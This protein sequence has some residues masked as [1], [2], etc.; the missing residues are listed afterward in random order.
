MA[1]P[2]FRNAALER[3]DITEGLPG[4]RL[5]LTLRLLHPDCTTPLADAWVDIWHCDAGGRYSGWSAIDPNVEAPS[6]EIGSIPRTDDDTYLRGHRLSDENGQVSF[7]TVFPGFYAGRAT[8][9]HVAVRQADALHVAYVGQL[10]FPPLISRLVSDS[11][12]YGS[13]PIT[14]LENH[15]DELYVETQTHQAKNLDVA[16]SSLTDPGDRLLGF[17]EFSLDLEA[18]SERIRPED[19]QQDSVRP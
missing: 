15:E 14:R 16:V 9:I 8:H 4:V 7:L 2:Y 18:R 5:E 6:G 12:A 19:L 1:G 3:F 17:V 10:Y 13:R 11:T